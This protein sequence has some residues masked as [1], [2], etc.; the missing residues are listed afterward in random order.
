MITV[1]ELI[2]KLQMF[3]L[4]TPCYAYEGEGIGI[5]IVDINDPTGE[6]GFVEAS[7]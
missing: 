4:D 5:V 6:L 2:Q 1:G 3:P 7:P